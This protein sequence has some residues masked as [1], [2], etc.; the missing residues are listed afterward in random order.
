MEAILEYLKTQPKEVLHSLIYDL[1]VDGKVSYHELMDLHIMNLERL[2]KGETEAYFRL[3][4][5]IVTMWADRKK[6]LRKNLKDTMQLLYDE[7]RVN[8]TQDKI[9]KYK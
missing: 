3:Q 5:K 1:M 9:D 4:S 6:N 8:I 7:G 2:K